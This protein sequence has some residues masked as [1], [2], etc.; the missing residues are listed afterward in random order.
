MKKIAKT[1]LVLLTVFGLISIPNSVAQTT[2][3]TYQVD[4]G[5]KTQ[6]KAQSVEMTGKLALDETGD[7]ISG[8]A[9]H[10]PLVS[11]KGVRGNYLSKIAGSKQNSDLNFI[12]NSINIKG[13]NVEVVGE[14]E[15]NNK[16]QPVTVKLKRKDINGKIVLTGNFDLDT[17]KYYIGSTASNVEVDKI[18]FNFTLVFSEP[19]VMERG[20]TLSSDR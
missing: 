14:L 19:V 6:V 8:M 18:P 17:S 13:N 20:L 2:K 7:D 11:F 9:L 3:I 10:V 5:S 1:V 4:S 15:F 12:S 16:F